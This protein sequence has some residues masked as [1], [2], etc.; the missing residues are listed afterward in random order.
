MPLDYTHQHLS[1]SIMDED[2]PHTPINPSGGVQTVTLLGPVSVAFDTPGVNNPDNFGPAV[3]TIPAGSLFQAFVLLTEAW[4]VDGDLD[5]G[6]AD[7][8]EGTNYAAVAIY[9]P[10]A[11]SIA[12]PKPGSLREPKHE[13]YNVEDVDTTTRLVRSENGSLR[14]GI[15]LEDQVLCVGFFPASTDPSAGSVDVYAL[16][17]TPA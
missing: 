9:F 15:A 4:D 3:L 12:N 13:S 17:A 10:Q 1:S 16:I 6:V 14:W 8:E 2:N 11:A 7:D 5:L